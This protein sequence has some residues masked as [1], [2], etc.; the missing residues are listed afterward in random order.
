[1]REK[2]SRKRVG[3]RLS[4]SHVNKVTDVARRYSKLG[5]CPNLRVHQSAHIVAINGPAPFTQYVLMVHDKQIDEDDEEDSGLYKVRVRYYDHANERW[6]TDEDTEYQLDGTEFGMTDLEEDDIV[7]GFWHAQRGMFIPTSVAET[8][9]AVKGT[10]VEAILETDA[11]MTI[12]FVTP[13]NGSNPVDGIGEGEGYELVVDNVHNHKASVG[14]RVD[15]W[16]NRTDKRWE[17]VQ[18]D[19]P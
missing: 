14:A 18:I 11:T 6:R 12:N 19:C 3:Q 7:V 8:I 13:I 10:L 15:A 9:R 4:A 5:I 17:E 16:Y 1:M 2:L